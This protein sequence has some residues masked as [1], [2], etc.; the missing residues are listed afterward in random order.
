MTLKEHIADL[1]KK[2]DALASNLDKAKRTAAL[3]TNAQVALRIF[4]SGESKTGK[5]GNYSTREML[6]TRSQFT[7]KSAFK[8]TGFIKFPRAS[9]PVAYMR[10]KGGY[11]QLRAIQGKATGTVNLDYTGATK[12]DFE[13]SVRPYKKGY[14]AILKRDR[15]AV[16]T[17]AME[18]KYRKKIFALNQRERKLFETTLTKELQ[19]WMLR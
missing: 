18:R 2:R 13:N 14:A 3:T 8:K 19:R 4:T 10:L 12:K 16:I 7:K 6:A 5:I 1:I 9:K 15:S 11:K 17:D